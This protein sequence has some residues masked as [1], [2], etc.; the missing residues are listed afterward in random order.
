[1]LINLFFNYSLEVPISCSEKS[2]VIT[3][4][5]E[6][7]S[8]LVSSRLEIPNESILEEVPVNQLEEPSNIL[9]ASKYDNY[10]INRSGKS[11]KI[12][13][14]SNSDSSSSPGLLD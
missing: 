5:L 7:N 11:A 8:E 10:N 3:T 12:V 4:S 13:Q 14:N 1:M 6:S 9:S 2:S